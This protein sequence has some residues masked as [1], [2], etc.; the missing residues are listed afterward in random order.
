MMNPDHVSV[1]LQNHH[2]SAT[3]EKDEYGEFIASCSE[4]EDFFTVGKSP[5]ESINNLAKELISYAHE[6]MDDFNLYYHST[7]RKN[8]FPFVFKILLQ[9]SI[10][11]VVAIIHVQQ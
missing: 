8:H 3:V 4:I 11:D 7:N 6:Y 10:E 1:L 9:N 5:Q 2:L